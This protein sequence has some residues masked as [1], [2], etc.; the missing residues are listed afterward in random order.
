MTVMFE[1]EA[2][3]HP[4]V[5]KD[6]LR[7]ALRAAVARQLLDHLPVQPEATRYTSH[8]QYWRHLYTRAPH[9]IRHTCMDTYDADGGAFVAMTYG[10]LVMLTYCSLLEMGFKAE[11][12]PSFGD[13]KRRQRLSV[14][15]HLFTRACLSN[16]GV[17]V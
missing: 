7:T 10:L 1:K 3:T 12:S 15:E 16:T 11:R 4:T 2:L 6:L 14:Q 5:Q 17:M 9:A 8:E 13:A